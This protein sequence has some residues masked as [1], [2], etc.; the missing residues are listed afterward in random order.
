MNERHQELAAIAALDLL[1]GAELAEW[2]Q[3]KAADP[4]LSELEAKL[5]QAA[6]EL[7]HLVPQTEP[8]AAL[9]QRI[10]SE[11]SQREAPKAPVI[12]IT[13][14]LA[15]GLAACFAVAAAWAGKT[16]LQLRTD[17]DILRQEQI[18]ADISI[19]R[20]NTELEAGKLINKQTV[21]ML[22]DELNKKD[23]LLASAAEDIKRASDISRFEISAMTSLDPNAPKS[24]AVAVWDQS[25]QDGVLEL[26]NM[27]NVGPDKDYQLW[28]IDPQKKLPVDAGVFKVD[29][30][31]GGAKVSFRSHEPISA[32]Q[33]FAVSVEKRGGAIQHE[34][35]I[36]LLS[37]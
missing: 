15:W 33:K 6:T 18:A 35:P 25:K 26:T 13:T 7:A 11:L 2:N 21:A 20:L 32:A 22:Q 10:M 9:K 24:L 31:T 23:S 3:A 17:N 5:R 1:E 28:V 27:P 34:G 14:Y 37:Q 30:G 29:S 12:S 8:P 19:K 4:S 16:A 36:V